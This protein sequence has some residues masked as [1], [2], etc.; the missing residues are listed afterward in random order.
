MDRANDSKQYLKAQEEAYITLEKYTD[1]T[2][3]IDPFDIVRKIKNIQLMTFT[4]FATDLKRKKKS[5]LKVEDII[6]QFESEHG[7]LKKKEKKKYIL[8]YNEKDPPWMIKWT[9][10]HEL[11]HYFMGHL[12]ENNV[13]LFFNEDYYEETKEAEANCFARHCCSPMPILKEVILDTGYDRSTYFLV[14]RMF[15]MGRAPTKYCSDH[16]DKYHIYYS[17]Y[18]YSELL[19]K[20][21][22]GINRFIAYSYPQFYKMA[23]YLDFIA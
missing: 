21:Q 7:F 10:F 5:K 4:E 17:R 12:T 23:T 8:C 22:K 16:F 9:I 1:G 19:K 6:S 15:D 3:P 18:K 13:T 20:Y 11:G 14:E 2:L